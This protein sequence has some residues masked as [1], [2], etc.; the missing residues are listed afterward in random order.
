MRKFKLLPSFIILSLFPINA[1]A[2]PKSDIA[3]YE[4]ALD[5][6]D[7]AQILSTLKKAFENTKGLANNDVYRA[8]IGY[9]Y[10]YYL[11]STGN[12]LDSLAPILAVKQVFELNP[13][14]GKGSDTNEINLIHGISYFMNIKKDFEANKIDEAIAKKRTQEALSIIDASS[15]PLVEQKRYDALVLVGLFELLRYNSQYNGEELQIQNAT[16]LIK[17]IENFEDIT[18]DDKQKFTTLGYYYRGRARILN[19]IHR[20]ATQNVHSKIKNESTNEWEDAVSDLYNAQKASGK[21]TSFAEKNYFDIQNW[22]NLVMSYAINNYPTDSVNAVFD[23]KYIEIFGEKPADNLAFYEK[24]HCSKYISTEFDMWI[25]DTTKYA[26]ITTAFDLDNNL[27]PINIKVLS[28]MPNN[29]VD[30]F[31]VNRINKSK[32]KKLAENIPTECY[33][34]IVKS[35]YF[36]NE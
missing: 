5:K 7:N 33:K 25:S 15:K 22:N 34:D 1:Y 28:S 35:Y 16:D 29:G 14:A 6:G 8:K 17:S 23:K 31:V 4:T 26:A 32:A 9:D 3:A 2:D 21:P 13:E 24:P 11:A 18:P 27:N 12:Y 19:T 36:Y 10:A 20:K 30:K